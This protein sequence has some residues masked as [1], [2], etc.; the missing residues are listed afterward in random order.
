M[1]NPIPSAKYIVVFNADTPSAW[2][3][4]AIEKMIANIAE[5]DSGMP[6][7]PQAAPRNARKEAGTISRPSCS[8]SSPIHCTAK[9]SGSP[10][11]TAG[12]S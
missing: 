10:T 6:R 11:T 1:Y 3:G 12:S 5:T 4:T 8:A 7:L 9:N 2:P